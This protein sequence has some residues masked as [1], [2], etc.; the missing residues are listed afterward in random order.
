VLDQFDRVFVINLDK[1][2]DR[3]Q[4]MEAQLQSIGYG[5]NAR[6]RRI[7]A[8]Q[9]GSA[10]GFR[11]VGA[12]GCFLSHLTCINEAVADNAGSLLIL[13]DDVDFVPGFGQLQK[14]V[15]DALARGGW[16]VF[17]GGHLIDPQQFATGTAPLTAGLR[18]VTADTG[19]VTAHCVAF[20]GTK[21][22]EVQDYLTAML[23]RQAGD[24][25]GG[26][27]DVDGA[28]SWY[29]RTSGARTAIADPQLAGQRASS[30]DITPRWFDTLPLVKSAANR[31]RQVLRSK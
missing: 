4:A 28:Y 5:F 6:I 7:S 2:A 11:S 18:S 26:P 20:A 8:T 1:R 10:E 24:P 29:R 13:E 23:G 30:S 21:L 22:R 14:P 3:L 12:R 25:Q 27:M 9:V 15:A 16:D 17:Y 19:I 31:L